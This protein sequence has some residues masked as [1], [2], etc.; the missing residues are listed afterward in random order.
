MNLIKMNHGPLNFS[1]EIINTNKINFQFVYKV[2]RTF[3][4]RNLHTQTHTHTQIGGD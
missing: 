1:H 4:T 2:D 3:Q